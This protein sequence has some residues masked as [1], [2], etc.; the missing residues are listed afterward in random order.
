MALAAT[1]MAAAMTEARAMAAVKAVRT[2][3]VWP[4]PHLAATGRKGA[5]IL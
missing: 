1:T 5:Y 3:F 2:S 4:P